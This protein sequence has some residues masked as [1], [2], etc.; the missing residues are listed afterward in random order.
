MERKNGEKIKKGLKGPSKV[1][2]LSQAKNDEPPSPPRTNPEGMAK[3]MRVSHLT[4]V[5]QKLSATNQPSYLLEM[6]RI[7]ELNLDVQEEELPMLRKM[8]REENCFEFN[9]ACKLVTEDQKKLGETK[10]KVAENDIENGT[11]NT[12]VDEDKDAKSVSSMDLFDMSRP[13]PFG[14]KMTP[15]KFQSVRNSPRLNGVNLDATS[16]LKR[17]RDGNTSTNN[18][19]VIK[20]KIPKRSSMTME[21][22]K[23]QG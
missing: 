6:P 15:S 17:S 11:E 14:Y 8:L 7:R 3:L 4:L 16:K 9:E 19:P 2:K 10:D 20:A 13:K 12:E 5:A 18:S 22:A 23:L 21:P 1:L